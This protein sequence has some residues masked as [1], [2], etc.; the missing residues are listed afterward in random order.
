MKARYKGC[1]CGKVQKNVIYEVHFAEV[2][3]MITV[4]GI[5]F[6]YKFKY[7]TIERLREDWEWKSKQANV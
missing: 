7:K 1:G 3:K 5:G 2:D 6:R 4:E